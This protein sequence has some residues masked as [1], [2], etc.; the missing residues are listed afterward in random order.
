LII[1]SRAVRSRFSPYA[2]DLLLYPAAVGLG[3]LAG[4]S[5]LM[6]PQLVKLLLLLPAL[7]FAVAVPPEKLF[8]GWLFS[9]PFVDGASAGPHSG[10]TF[11]KYLFLVPP[12]ILVARMATGGLRRP[13]LWIIDVLP[14]LY[15]AYIVVRVQLLPSDFTGG[16]ANNR[17]IYATVGIGI[18]GYYFAGFGRTGDRFPVRVASSLLWG[19]IIVAV[20]ALVDAATGWNLWN[21]VEAGEGTATRRVVST[22]T[23]PGALGAYIGAGVVFSVAILAWKGPRS[24]RLPA[25]LLIPLSIPALFFTYSRGPV[26]GAAVVAVFI[27]LVANRARLPSLLVFATVAILAFAVWQQISSS[28]VY[29]GRLGVTETVTT[30][31]E[32]QRVTLELIRQKPVFGW[33]YNT[34]DKAKLTVPSRDPRF[35]ELSSH[36]TF[37]TVLA[38]LGVVGLTL[39]LLPWFVIGYRAVSA[40]W[41]GQAEKWIVGACVGI[42]AAYALGALTYD[43]RFFS[44][45]TA[46]PWIALGVARSLLASQRTSTESVL[47]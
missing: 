17:A 33:G 45:V 14:A 7:V 44:L 12:V 9:A 40:A 10:H 47:P 42:P 19:A 23:S 43:T 32:I 24:L 1:S 21:T 20:L 38:E 16:E 11:Y 36:S 4:Y 27:L 3:L 5:L 13:R 30:R 26:L 6:S 8:V 31:Q 15:L 34:F 46:L 39:L 35:D 29:R 37:L 2:S 22:F 25:I 41:R 28:T 18:I